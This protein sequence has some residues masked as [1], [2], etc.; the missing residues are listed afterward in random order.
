MV[1]DMPETETVTVVRSG[2]P[3]WLKI[4]QWVALGLVSMAALAG[5]AVL[6]LD[7]QPG[8]RLI[9]DQLGKLKLES[10]L[11]FRIG[12][13]DGSIY[14]GMILRDVRV[15]D[16]QG[17]FATAQEIKLDWRPLA[18]LK[19]RIDIRNLESPEIRLARLPALKPSGDP[20]AP[21]LPDLNI[22]IA[23][24]NVARIDIA[25]TVDGQRHIA[26]L[27]GSAHLA[28]GRAQI[29]A[30]AGTIAARGVAG[31][32]RLALK[33]DAVPAANRLDIDLRLEAPKGGL[34]AGLA[35]LQAPLMGSVQ[36]AG[37]WKHWQ[38]KGLATLGGRTLADLGV[39]ADNGRFQVR[40]MTYP[41]LYMT[42]PVE[43]L[44]APGLRLDTDFRWADRKA[45]GI[46]KIKSD[47]LSAQAQGLVDLGNN[48]FHGVH[49]DAL[50]LKP[51]TIAPKLVGR[52]V[53]ASL[54][55]EG[56]FATP[57][58]D[59]KLSAGAIGFGE[60][61]V[62]KLY[63]EGRARVDA[64]RILVPVRARAARVSGLN[65]A[66]GGLVTNVTV[67]GD[68]AISGSRILS[69]NLR[70]KSDKIDATAIVAADMAKGRYTG[71]LKGRINDYTIAGVGV[72][73]LNTDAELY[74]A[75]GGGWGIRGKVA[76]RSRKL[77][78]EGVRNFLGGNTVASAR[79]NLDPKGVIG[80]ADVRLRAPQ[81]RVLRGQGTYD[82][83]GPIRLTADAVSDQYGPLSARV[84]GTL[85][86]PQL[87]LRAEKPGLGV[88]LAKVEAK[89]IGR[90]DA[91]A[92][93]ATGESNYG[94]FNAD[95]LVRTGRA[96]A[97]QVNAAK[98]AGMDIA[99]QLQATPSGPFAGQ[100]TFRG[101]GVD[102]VATLGAEGKFQRADVRATADNAAI[103]GV[104][105]LT[106]GRAIA[107]ASIVLAEQPQLVADVQIA[108]L[109]R[110][111]FLLRTARAKID[112]RGGNGTVQAVAS[113]SSGVAFDV[114]LNGRMTPALWTAALQGQ[115]SGV[116][117]HTTAPAQIAIEKGVYRLLPTQINFD[118]GSVRVAG[119][120]GDGTVVQARLDKL[121][122]AIVNAFVP[123]LGIGGT[124][125]GS[126]DFAQVSPEAFP[127]A[128]ARLEVDDLTRSSLVRVSTPVHISMVGKLLPDGGDLRALI[129]RGNTTIGRIVTTLSPLGPGAGSWTERLMAAPLSGGIRYNGPAALPFA[130]AGLPN[131]QLTGAI[132]MAADFTGRVDRPLLNGVVRAD[133]LTYDNEAT[134]TRLTN[135]KIDGQFSNDA[136]VLNQLSARAGNGS[137]TASGRVGLSSAEGFPMAITVK[138][139]DARLARSEALGAT[140]SGT[141]TVTKN[142]EVQK[143]E[144]Q[145][146]IPEANYQI[147][148][149]GA[150]EIPELTGVRRKG[151]VDPNQQAQA[152]KPA[153][154]FGNFDLAIRVRADNRLMVSG[155]GLE[156]EW[157]AN[158][159]IGGT[160]LDPQIRGTMEV[161][162]GTY[163][164]ASRRFELTKGVISFQGAE[165]T[166]PT[167]DISAN[168]TAEGVTAILNITGTA[169]KP[170]IAF[171]SN[172]ALPQD[173]VLSRLF[174][175]TN[176]T[177]LSATEAIQLAAALNSLR[178]TGGGLNPL[179]QLKSATG[180]DRLRVLGADDTTGRG[181]SL[182]AGKYITNN[183]YI[184][185]I[186]DARGFTAT[187]LEVSLS[188]A[189]SVLS[190]TSSF[191]GSGATLR[192][193]RDY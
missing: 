77:F 155:M 109:K 126:V 20:N 3:L 13:I 56:A 15:S 23:R 58:V 41:G 94:P 117:F 103:P 16:T 55:L 14:G 88:G 45:D 74:T 82:P 81:F 66:A 152:K 176:V 8:R 115:A 110:G 121:D 95:V 127:S 49:V 140:A 178:A 153:R 61:V 89:V 47:A 99:G 187:Q 26:R 51:G 184:E 40:G 30:N 17:V 143:I 69:D 36:G 120:Y 158:I 119:R 32:D 149:Q 166:N 84:T 135:L 161:V 64:D 107:T 131:Q 125:T 12:R 102:G 27:S 78:N 157:Q 7:T 191:G 35:K 106:I 52:S 146:N 59:Y 179:G 1:N 71:A 118:Q 34:V 53:R 175:G 180:I 33:L 80:I 160:T 48:Q 113:G 38:G 37:D 18:Y 130:F 60:T 141:L 185:I 105:E 144:G 192:Y 111:E 172:P 173:E 90:G 112:Y 85:N 183:I 123:D 22:D 65:A 46:V 150:A 162:R 43:R 83:A 86:A 101:S 87:L 193:S 163:S 97:I 63:A 67:D 100:L 104:S 108:N 11:G 189:L 138:L 147:I 98:F 42:G 133:N 4:V 72:V 10:G 182:A 114:A 186:T 6:G 39:T 151:D 50:L 9:A 156:S 174:F 116:K 57:M 31:G 76:G 188:R 137:V 54:A 148:R 93:T 177:N 142:A 129:R 73:D 25:P 96:L 145:I 168:T 5:L 62:E 169:Q 79:L 132:G 139:D 24:L 44:T 165:L 28:D 2:R 70:L 75:P 136:F 92:V 29:F 164:F 167:I 91:Y 134:G 170:S 68:L 181:T 19:N 21:L 122:L 159:T 124:A 190:Q 128:D 154:A 171:T